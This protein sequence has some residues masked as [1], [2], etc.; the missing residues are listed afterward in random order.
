ME[1]VRNIERESEMKNRA[2]KLGEKLGK[3]KSWEKVLLLAACRKKDGGGAP[4][5]TPVV[6][7]EQLGASNTMIKGDPFSLSSISSYQISA[8]KLAAALWE[9]QHY[10]TPATMYFG[11]NNPHRMRRHLHRVNKDEAIDHHH[12]HHQTLPLD[13][14]RGGS[15]DHHQPASAGSLRRHIASSLVRHQ[16]A[17]RN[18]NGLQPLSPASFGSSL[19]ANR[20]EIDELMKQ[21]S[22]DSLAR[23]NKE[24]ER[25][26]AALQ[27]VRDE[28]EDERKLRKRSESLHR[29][30]ARELFEMKVALSTTAKELERER[31]SSELLEELCD[32][33]AKGIREYATQLHA[34]KQ[35]TDKDWTVMTDNDN[36][37][38][39][40]SESWL[41]ERMQVKDKEAQGSTA[42]KTSVVEKLSHEIEAF[43]SARKTVSLRDP[44]ETRVRRCSLESIPEAYTPPCIGHEDAAFSDSRRV[45]ISK[46]GPSNYE[47]Q[48]ELAL[49]RR[50]KGQTP[51]S[52][53][54]S[55]IQSTPPETDAKIRK[56]S[57]G[58]STEISMLKK[59]D[60]YDTIEGT[61]QQKRAYN[62]EGEGSNSKTVDKLMS[63]LLL[64]EGGSYSFPPEYE[65][66]EV[67]SSKPA[68]RRN[69]SP[70]RQWMTS[71][72]SLD[73]RVSESSSKTQPVRDNTLKAKLQEPKTKGQRSHLKILK[74]S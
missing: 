7:W 11:V 41:D 4:C 20:R 1:T 42:H 5:T 36:L 26:D 50:R 2:E 65:Y 48:E 39:H 60:I 18:H 69:A 32:E 46:A 45:E 61:R 15:P 58:T 6:S 27:S 29:K 12:H 21:I 51:P 19:E 64:S 47:E 3:E 24:Q 43:L 23:K 52:L 25:I 49:S 59:S 66:K 68:L 17:D 74:S 57:G 34:T 67:S 55:D 56:T 37:L 9:F 35:K 31:R 22:E 16:S 14:D 28:L 72:T 53:Q 8:R 73:P 62:D 38:L 63:E 44:Q 30:L 71:M 70:V 33:F 54:M 10:F 40:I 13:P